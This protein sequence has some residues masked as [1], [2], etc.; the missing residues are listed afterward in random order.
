MTPQHGESPTTPVAS[1]DLYPETGFINNGS[2]SED[3]TAATDEICT[4]LTPSSPNNLYDS[5]SFVLPEIGEDD[6]PDDDDDNQTHASTKSRMSAAFVQF[7]PSIQ[8][9]DQESDLVQMGLNT[10]DAA[11]KPSHIECVTTINF[12]SDPN[13]QQQQAPPMPIQVTVA[14]HR[15]SWKKPMK[16]TIMVEEVDRLEQQ[17][18]RGNHGNDNFSVRSAPSIVR[19]RNSLT[20]KMVP[21]RNQRD[22]AP[23]TGIPNQPHQIRPPGTLLPPGPPSRS[24]SMGPG[25]NTLRRLSSLPVQRRT[26]YMPAPVG[27]ETGISSNSD[28]SSSSKASIRSTA[29]APVYQDSITAPQRSSGLGVKLTPKN[30]QT[31]TPSQTQRPAR[32]ESPR[33]DPAPKQKD[34]KGTYSQA[35]RPARAAPPRTDPAPKQ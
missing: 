12:L 15:P 28:H 26:S 1:K 14:S 27:P 10:V 18:L 24:M 21:G 2:G 19:R 7:S 3:G 6:Y 20:N 33:T 11:N 35:Q 23:N 9:A 22:R 30:V 34:K 32:I 16:K 13:Q 29:S 31:V 17:G 4:P 5:P 25:N 8:G